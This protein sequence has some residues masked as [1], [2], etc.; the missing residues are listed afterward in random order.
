M[1]DEGSREHATSDPT[2]DRVSRELLELLRGDEP[3]PP[4][5]L[6]HGVLSRVRR[7]LGLRDLFDGLA[8]GLFRTV[9]GAL[10]RDDLEASRSSDPAAIARAGRNERNRPPTP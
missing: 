6:V 2:D 10:R 9:A 7:L 8:L 4:R 3:A 5:A 1:S